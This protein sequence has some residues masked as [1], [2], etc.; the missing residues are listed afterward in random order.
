MLVAY[1]ILKMMIG[2]MADNGFEKNAKENWGFLSN[3]VAQDIIQ[4]LGC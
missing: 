4:V 1:D 3:V 2:V